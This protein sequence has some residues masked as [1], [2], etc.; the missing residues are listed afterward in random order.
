VNYWYAIFLLHDELGLLKCFNDGTTMKNLLAMK[1]W[2]KIN[3]HFLPTVDESNP[4]IGFM[5][6]RALPCLVWKHAAAAASKR[7]RRNSSATSPQQ[8]STPSRRRSQQGKGPR[9]SR[10]LLRKEEEEWR[11]KEEEE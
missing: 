5:R 7:R 9:P 6:M 3:P 11:G 10:R 1:G 4:G 2:A 8:P